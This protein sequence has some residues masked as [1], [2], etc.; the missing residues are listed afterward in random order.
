MRYEHRVRRKHG[1]VVGVYG[2]VMRIGPIWME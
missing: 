2:K 1:D